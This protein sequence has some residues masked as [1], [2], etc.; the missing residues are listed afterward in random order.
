MSLACFVKILNKFVQTW[1]IILSCLICRFHARRRSERPKPIGRKSPV[2]MATEDAL[3][4]HCQMH[5]P[6][7][8]HVVFIGCWCRQRRRRRNVQLSAAL[9]IF[10]PVAHP[11]QAFDVYC[12]TTEFRGGV[13]RRQNGRRSDDYRPP[14]RRAVDPANY[15]RW[16]HDFDER[17]CANYWRRCR[18]PSRGSQR[19]YAFGCWRRRRQTAKSEIAIR[20][21]YQFS[22]NRR[23][24]NWAAADSETTSELGINIFLI[25]HIDFILISRLTERSLAMFL[26]RRRVR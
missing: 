17:R 26:D 22:A 4:W 21:R 5:S 19:R 15:I 25:T 6:P 7:T 20:I 3:A 2:T 12:T 16:Q 13:C 18:G 24:P 9:C 23:L 8:L 10:G 1:K 14:R 11:F